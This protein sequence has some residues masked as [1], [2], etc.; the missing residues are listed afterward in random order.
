MALSRHKG[1]TM[2]FRFL[3]RDYRRWRWCYFRRDTVFFCQVVWRF[4]DSFRS[5]C[6][7][8]RR[9]QYDRFFVDIISSQ[10]RAGSY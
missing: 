9:W 10:R 6:H 2:A 7:R 8:L 1:E 3:L 4:V 5:H